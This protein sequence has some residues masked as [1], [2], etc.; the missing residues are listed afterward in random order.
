MCEETPLLVL[1]TRRKQQGAAAAASSSTCRAGRETSATVLLSLNTEIQS[2]PHDPKPPL[3]ENMHAC[4][5]HGRREPSAYSWVAA[6]VS[7]NKRQGQQRRRRRRPCL[8][9]HVNALQERAEPGK[10]PLS[11]AAAASARRGARAPTAPARA[12]LLP[13]PS[14][15]HPPPIQAK[16]DAVSQKSPAHMHGGFRGGAL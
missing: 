10:T 16:V 9:Q 6:C 14:P 2:N 4:A 11:V 7:K 13:P 8:L 3:C 5:A 1:S 12:P 15:R